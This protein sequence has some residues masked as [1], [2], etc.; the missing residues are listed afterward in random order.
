[1]NESE[2]SEFFSA[3][4]HPIR[5]KILK[6]LLKGE[7]F[8]SELAKDIGISR[9]LLYLHLNKLE[10]AGLVETYV[11]NFPTPPYAKKYVRLRKLLIKFYLPKLELEIEEVE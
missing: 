10:K 8:V 11:K 1:M 6:S 7:K 5:I 2:L 9:P 3:L 4:S